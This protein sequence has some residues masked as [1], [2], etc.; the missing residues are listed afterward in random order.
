MKIVH[1]TEAWQ[2]GISTYVNTLLD[3]QARKHAVT[4]VYSAAQTRSDFDEDFY[5]ARH[6]RVV[7][8]ST[9]RNPVKIPAVIKNLRSLLRSLQPDIIHLHSTFP[10]LYGRALRAPAP[11]IYCPHGWSFVQ[12]K[13]RA[14][15]IVYGL[16]ERLL[17][18]RCDAIINISG[19]EGEAARRAKIHSAAS[20]VIPSG[21]N[22]TAHYDDAP[23]NDEIH[24][25]FI[26]RL[27]YKKGFDIVARAFKNLHRRDIHLH[28][29]GAAGRDGHGS[30]AARTPNIHYHGWVPNAQIDRRLRMLDAVI[31]PSRQEGFGLVVVEAMRNGVPALVSRAGGLPELVEN[32]RN[33]YIF[34]ESDL[35]ELLENL[36]KNHLRAMGANART[37]YEEKYT[38]ARMADAIDALY[39]RVLYTRKISA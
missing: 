7:P 19:H 29:F 33:G 24:I 23:K 9:S 14:K 12:E 10:G 38:A 4:L 37:L 39:D 26:G 30:D 13:G 3:H 35:L 16:A 27:D 34:G 32:G 21:V 17:A 6:I 8:Y 2:G 36:D 15:R 25:G 11:V 20:I 28:V 5:K 22:D 1:V 18:R 31:V